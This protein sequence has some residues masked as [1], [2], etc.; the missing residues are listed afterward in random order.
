M[1]LPPKFAG[2]SLSSKAVHTIELCNGPL[3]HQST[4]KFGWF[5]T[6][7][8]DYVCPVSCTTNSP[9][10]S[11]QTRTFWK[12]QLV[13]RQNVQNPA[14]FNFPLPPFSVSWRPLHLT[15]TYPTVASVQHA[16][17]W[18]RCRSAPASTREVLAVQCSAVWGSERLLW[19]Q[20]RE[21]DPEWD[22][23]AAGKVGS[24]GGHWCREFL[25]VAQGS[26]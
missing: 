2:Q 11:M 20:R 1:A 6:S 14:H 3:Y 5:C 23:R 10:F 15:P 4:N 25:G 26:R 19:R 21:R 17:S 8:L 12:E 24:E 13:L 9:P 22:L 7:D 18:S 16:L